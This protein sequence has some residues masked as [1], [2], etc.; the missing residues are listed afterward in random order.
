MLPCSTAPALGHVPGHSDRFRD[1]LML[2]SNSGWDQ[3]ADLLF[4]WTVEEISSLFFPGQSKAWNLAASWPRGEAFTGELTRASRLPGGGAPW[5][6]LL[7]R[8]QLF[9]NPTNC[10]PPGSS[11]H[12]IF[13][14]R[15]LEWVAMSSSGGSP[16]PSDRTC[17]S[18]ASSVGR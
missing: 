9:C 3:G 16:W 12:G 1:G 14:A 7:S 15:I 6:Q 18:C 4:V 13:Q 8:V 10:S 17:V 2:W 11:A 5:A